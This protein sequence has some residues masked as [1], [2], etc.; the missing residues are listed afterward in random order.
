MNALTLSTVQATIAR[1][2]AGASEQKSRITRAL[3][4]ILLGHCQQTAAD[5]FAVESATTQGV[6]YIVTPTGCECEGW[7]RDQSRWCSHQWAAR[8]LLAARQQQDRPT[9]A[10]TRAA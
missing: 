6:T 9:V 8:I 3:P 7:R 2:I 10:L 5:E 4:L 1:A